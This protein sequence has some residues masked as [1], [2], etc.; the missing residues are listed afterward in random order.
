MC[1][2][3]MM[4]L[5]EAILSD[6]E[7]RANYIRDRIQNEKRPVLTGRLNYPGLYKNASQ[8]RYGFSVLRSILTKHL[9]SFQTHLHVWQGEDGQT[10]IM[11]FQASV[12]AYEIKRRVLQIENEHILGRLFD[13]DVFNSDSHLIHREQLGQ[14]PRKCFLCGED[15]FVCASRGIHSTAE[16]LAYCNALLKSHRNIKR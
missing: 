11:M 12:D 15:T 1:A 2:Y 16:K 9:E 14:S 10:V 6:R 13:I 8:A 5:A 7:M 4:Q 3:Q